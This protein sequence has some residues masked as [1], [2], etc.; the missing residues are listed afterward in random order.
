MMNRFRDPI[1]ALTHLIGGILSVIGI[2]AMFWLI[3]AENNVTPL[4]VTSVLAFGLGLICLYFTSF[5]YH[6]SLGSEEK[7]LRLRKLDHSMVFILIA[8]SYTPFCLLCLTG[9][10][11]M[12]MMIAIWG[13]AILGIV[14]KVAWIQMPRWLGTALYIFLG[15]FALFVLVPLYYALSLAGFLLLIGGGVMYTVGGVIYAMKKPNLSK[16]FGFHEL[17]HIFVI[18]GSLCHFICVFFFIL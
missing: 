17:F 14:L 2:I 5:T 1:N 9:T 6:A 13:V 15:W 11:R 12:V 8:G 4:T 3:I 16:D 7:V 10:M 18:L